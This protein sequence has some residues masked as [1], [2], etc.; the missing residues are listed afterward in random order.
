MVVMALR[1]CMFKRCLL[2]FLAR[3]VNVAVSKYCTVD[4]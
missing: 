3:A 1:N 4:R 2:S